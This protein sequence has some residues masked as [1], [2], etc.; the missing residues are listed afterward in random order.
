MADIIAPLPFTLSNG[1]PA[2][3]SQVQANLDQIRNDV[4]NNAQSGALGNVNGP[5]SSLIGHIAV[6]ADTTGKLLAD[7]GPIL[8]G[9]T[10]R[11]AVVQKTANQTLNNG[12]TVTVS[13]D[14]ETIDTD[15][16]HS[17]ITNNSRLTV[18]SGITAVRFVI[19][20]TTANSLTP[21]GVS[22]RLNG[23][24]IVASRENF[25]VG[26]DTIVTNNL[27]YI[28]PLISCASGDYFELRV[29]NVS[30]SINTVIEGAVSYTPRFTTFEMQLLG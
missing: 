6:F 5:A 30:G 21:L 10:Y 14:K 3:A 9:G 12:A 4:N 24:T 29:T 26:D 16:I 13:F 2:D 18:P 22:V 11:G 23:S 1:D 25:A 17:N 7:G 20:V 8:A 19:N 15:G 27:A 28:T